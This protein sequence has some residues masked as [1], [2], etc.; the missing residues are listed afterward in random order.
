M[1]EIRLTTKGEKIESTRAYYIIGPFRPSLDCRLLRVYGEEGVVIASKMSMVIQEDSIQMC[2][3]VLS[4][5]RVTFQYR[6]RI[7]PRRLN[8]APKI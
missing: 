5:T 4:S 1:I 7:Q 6:Y 2:K 3:L 8:E